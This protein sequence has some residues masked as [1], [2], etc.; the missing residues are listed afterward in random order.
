[1]HILTRHI[2]YAETP[3][4][5]RDKA[6]SNANDLCEGGRPFDWFNMDGDRYEDSGKAFM[7]ASVKGKKLIEE[8]FESHLEERK[9]YWDE[10]QKYLS[11]GGTFEKLFE[12]E[13]MSMT[14]Y[15]F[16]ALGTSDSAGYLY[17]NDGECI[18]DRKHL[19]NA[20]AK[21]ESKDYQ[22]DDVYVVCIDMH[23]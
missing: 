9:R 16:Q 1:M 10:V 5:A 21:W 17:D 8:M 13:S 3:E 2:V 18:V 12:D 22:N 7:A 15:Y 20:L 6:E 14:R 11:E 23:F 4:E 19:A